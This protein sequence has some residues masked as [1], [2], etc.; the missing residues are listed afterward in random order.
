MQS[1][2]VGI[3]DYWQTDTQY[4][5]LE[6]YDAY[7]FN[8]LFSRDWDSL[9]IIH[10]VE[11]PDGSIAYIHLEDNSLSL[12]KMQPAT[13]DTLH[14]LN[15]TLQGFGSF[16]LSPDGKEIVIT[17]H[18]KSVRRVD[19]ETGELIKDLLYYSPNYTRYDP[20][21]KFL[22]LSWPESHPA[23]ATAY[24]FYTLYD[25]AR[26]K[27]INDEI[28]RRILSPYHI[29][30]FAWISDSVY[31]AGVPSRFGGWGDE[32]GGIVVFNPFSESEAQFTFTPS[33]PSGDYW[34]GWN[35]GYNTEVV[36][37]NGNVYYHTVSSDG[38][39]SVWKID[40]IPSSVAQQHSV[41]LANYPNPAENR[42]T[43]QFPFTVKPNERFYV[44]DASG[45]SFR[46][47]F[48]TG[49]DQTEGVFDI[50]SLPSGA[51]MVRSLSHPS[52]VTQFIKQ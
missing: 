46:V 34:F 15:D 2:Y 12:V 5:T 24:T 8:K 23:E 31:I 45:R 42:I 28:D 33:I 26:N 16:D 39:L 49:E 3:A 32:S 38:T 18:Y 43:I 50:S 36:K 20:T 10:L 4:F 27:L 51:Y 7:T 13:G 6:K 19:T 21:G 40:G 22:L 30:Y 52:A 25:I 17:Q 37:K 14:F 11:S 47:S 9:Y 1:F 48:T 44:T 29:V 35:Y 41:Q